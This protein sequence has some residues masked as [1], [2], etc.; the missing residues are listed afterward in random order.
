[1][2]ASSLE[3]E[4]VAALIASRPYLHQFVVG[5]GGGM[6]T[7]ELRLAAFFLAAHLR[8]GLGTEVGIAVTYHGSGDE[9]H[10][11]LIP[12]STHNERVNARLLRKWTHDK[13]KV[14]HERTTGVVGVGAGDGGTGRATD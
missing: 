3:Q 4:I 9:R 8:G 7:P 6:V 5:H 11:N 10:M 2:D 12:L 14:G 13:Q 1:M